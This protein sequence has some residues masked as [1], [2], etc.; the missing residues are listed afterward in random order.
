MGC[1]KLTKWPKP[2][3][4]A[5]ENHRILIPLTCF[6][7][8]LTV[9]I[10]TT[11]GQVAR[12]LEKKLKPKLEP[13]KLNKNSPTHNDVSKHQWSAKW[14]ADLTVIYT[15]AHRAPFLGH[16]LHFYFWFSTSPSGPTPQYENKTHIYTLWQRAV[17]L[18]FQHHFY[19]LFDEVQ[20]YTVDF[21]QLYQNVFY[22]FE[23][24]F[25]IT[26]NGTKNLNIYKTRNRKHHR[27]AAKP[28]ACAKPLMLST[29]VN[30][31][32]ICRTEKVILAYR[33]E[34]RPTEIRFRFVC[35][36]WLFLC[37]RPFSFSTENAPIFGSKL[38]L[39]CRIQHTWTADA[40]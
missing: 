8:L 21:W 40:K 28:A 39:K 35:Q 19:A 27:A 5:C 23:F 9:L 10:S 13:K 37:F 12:G 11:S 2:L 25:T 7:Y 34:Q 38:S 6:T 32:K 1:P 33:L 24:F 16:F 4:I 29:P 18:A 22:P 36:K 31:W 17:I 3:G 30:N 26:V 20:L 14:L 15:V